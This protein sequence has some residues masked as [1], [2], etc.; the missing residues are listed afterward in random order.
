MTQKLLM[1]L[2]PVLG[3]VVLAN[4]YLL[5]EPNILEVLQIV[6]GKQTHIRTLRSLMGI[7]ALIIVGLSY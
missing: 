6:E 5:L 1:Y 3:T 4:V 2:A 7:P